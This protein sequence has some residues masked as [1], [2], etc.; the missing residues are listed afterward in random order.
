MRVRDSP[1]ERAATQTR[2][3][4]VDLDTTTDFLQ[5][6]T[7][8]AHDGVLEEEYSAENRELFNVMA[9]RSEAECFYSVSRLNHTRTFERKYDSQYQ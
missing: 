6:V 1:H 5:R 7:V 8:V 4:L 2:V 9:I 3:P